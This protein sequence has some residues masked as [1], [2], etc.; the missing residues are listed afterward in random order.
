MKMTRFAL[1]LALF[2]APVGVFAEAPIAQDATRQTADQQAAWKSFVTAAE[3][4]RAG[5]DWKQAILARCL[6]G[7]L[8]IVAQ[9]KADGIRVI[10]PDEG[11]MACGEYG[12]GRLAEPAAIVDALREFVGK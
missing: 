5:L 10:D 12:P 11:E 1:A 4:K 6:S 7:T 9:L 3:L 2:A 8:L